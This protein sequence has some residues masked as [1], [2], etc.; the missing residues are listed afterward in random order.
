MLRPRLGLA[1][2]VGLAGKE[3][4][5]RV[6]EP[7]GAFDVRQVSGGKLDE[8]GLRDGGGQEFAIRGWSRRVVSTGDHECLC[9]DITRFGAKVGVAQGRTAAQVT[10]RGHRHQR[11]ADS[12]DGAR[13]R[14]AEGRR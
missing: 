7:S 3:L 10:R 9:A 11:R 14:G 2:G 12:C 6:A 4:A 8:H 5:D 1:A 13:L